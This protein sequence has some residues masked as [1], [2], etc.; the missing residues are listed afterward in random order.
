MSKAAELAALIGSQTAQGNRNLIINGAM[1]VSQRG[2]VTGITST[3]YGGPDRFQLGLGSAGTWTAAQSTDAPVGFS[4]SYKLD[5]TTA[6]A[7]LGGTDLLVF[8]QAI[9]GQNL[10]HL[11]KGTSS[12]ESVTVSFYVKSNKTGTYIAE[13][14]DTDNSRQISQAYTISSA[15]TWEKK[16]LT[17]AGD[18]SGAL[19]NDNAA[20]FYFVCWLA[21]GSTYSSGTL[22]TTWTS[23]TAANRAVGQV[24]LAD[25]TDNE[26]HITGIQMEIGEQATPF[27]HRTFADD[28][29]ACMRYYEKQNADE[30]QYIGVGYNESTSNGRGL[31]IFKARKRAAPTVTDSG[32]HF[33]AQ[34]TG[35]TGNAADVT[36]D[37]ASPDC[38]RWILTN[39]NSTLVDGGASLLVSK[40]DDSFIQADAEL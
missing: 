18:T 36:F 31:V 17:Y 14:F 10:Q 24:N 29:T 1:Q 22:S 38:V 6:D 26:W 35:T 7:S 8:Q 34:S 12:A 28:L 13:L 30:N 39:S 16:T 2:D 33:A 15:D 9:E 27:E 20:S 32:T 5:C 40:A 3:S 4:N 37:A 23:Q 11:K 25:S 19:D 21:A